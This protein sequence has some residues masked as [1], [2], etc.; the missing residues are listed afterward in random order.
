MQALGLE[1]CLEGLLRYLVLLAMYVLPL[2][3]ESGSG[4][5]LIEEALLIRCLPHDLSLRAEKIG[6]GASTGQLSPVKQVHR[7]APAAE[8]PSA[9]RGNGV[10]LQ[11]MCVV[12][13]VGADQQASSIP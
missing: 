2:P 6:G 4:H 8:E 7:V 5:Q 9:S 11:K 1:Y 13:E 10:F 12:A 3:K